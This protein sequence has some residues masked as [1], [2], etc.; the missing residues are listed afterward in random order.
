MNSVSSQNGADHHQP[1]DRP[2]SSETPAA[3]ARNGQ[4]SRAMIG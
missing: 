2:I 3:I 1:M 4:P